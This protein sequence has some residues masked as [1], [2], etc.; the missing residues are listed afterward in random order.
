MANSVVLS[1]VILTMGPIGVQ[2]ET[3][4]IGLPELNV[5]CTAVLVVQSVVLCDL[6]L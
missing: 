6:L 2:Y 4:P 5:C 3:S 1:D